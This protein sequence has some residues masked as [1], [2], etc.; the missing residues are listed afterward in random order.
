MDDWNQNNSSWSGYGDD[1]WDMPPKTS[2]R[3]TRH[4]RRD[5]SA[6]HSAAPGHTIGSCD[7]DYAGEA[8]KPGRKKIRWRRIVLPLVIALI[9]AGAAL[10]IRS[11]L[12]RLYSVVSPAPSGFGTADSNGNSDNDFSVDINP[13]GDSDSRSESEAELTGPSDID[14]YTPD[15]SF[16]LETVSRAGI[17]ELS[18]QEIYAR[19][20]PSVVSIMAY[21]DNAG[22][23]ATGVILSEDGYILTNQHVVAGCSAARVVT[24][25]NESYDALLVGED[26]SSATV[27]NW[28]WA[29]SA[30]PSA[31]R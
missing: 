3:P 9:A 1:P 15:G 7:A 6:G 31:T 4:T 28:W 8:V 2:A 11:K 5:E 12:Y 21:S 18:Y 22:S 26:A 16:T 17:E 13:D 20:A 27:R 19:V 14:R 29:T 30:L 24:A 23:Y 25:D 10:V